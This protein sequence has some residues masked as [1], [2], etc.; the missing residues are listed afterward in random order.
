MPSNYEEISQ[1]NEK[2]YG[3]EIGR[4]GQMLLADRYDDRNRPANPPYQ[5]RRTCLTLSFAERKTRA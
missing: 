3:T 5:G 1:D 4:I 2:R